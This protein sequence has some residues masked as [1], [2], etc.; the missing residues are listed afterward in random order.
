MV[1]APP[2][3]VRFFRCSDGTDEKLM[4]AALAK[5]QEARKLADRPRPTYTIGGLK[6]RW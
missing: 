5:V 1:A 4:T 3:P 2:P 6:P